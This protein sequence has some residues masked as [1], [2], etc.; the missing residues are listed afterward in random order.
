ML[1]QGQE[2]MDRVGLSFS[3]PS[4]VNW[5]LLEKNRG[6]FNLYRDLIGLRSAP[7]S[8]LAQGRF[9]CTHVNDHNKVVSYRRFLANGHEYVILANFSETNFREYRIGLAGKDAELVFASNS[10]TYY[11]DFFNAEE[12]SFKT[13][14]GSSYDRLPHTLSVNLAPY[15]FLIFDITR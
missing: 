1:F 4:I 11:P 13:L 10:N 7:I 15:Q 12:I 8:P 9:Q 14:E 3:E 5:S 6:M 2:F